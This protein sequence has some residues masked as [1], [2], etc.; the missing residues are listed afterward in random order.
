MGQRAADLASPA[1]PTRVRYQVL[2][3]A[4]SLAV[5]TYLQRQG[6]IA[7]TPYIKHDLKLDDE[8]LADLGVLALVAYGLFQVP[9]GMLGDRL[10]ARRLLTLLVFSWSILAGVVALARDLPTEGSLV[11]IFLGTQRFLFAAFQAGAFPGLTRVLADWMPARQRGFAQGMVWTFTR[12]GGFVAPI[13]VVWLITAIFGSREHPNWAIPCW[14]LAGVGLIWCVFFAI[15]FRNRPEEMSRVNAAEVA[16]IAAGRSAPQMAR[17]PLAWGMFFKLRNVWAICLM[18]GFLGYSGNFITQLLNVYLH[19][20]RHLGDNETAWAAGLPL[21]FG[22]V[23]CLLGGVVSDWLIRRLGDRKWGRR[24]VGVVVM[25]LAGLC[26][27][28][29]PWV[30]GFWPLALAFSAWFF[31]NDAAM[32]PAWASC[33]DV[34]DR[35]AGTL[36]GAMNMTGAFLGRWV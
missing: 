33:T 14:L 31:F 9:C 15:W 6:F 2:A 27:M 5:L 23:S 32:A 12:L 29:I 21:G 8:Q 24:L 20:H 26:S 35:H 34:G 18:Y 17:E 16:L 19:D 10:G 22:I 36:G 13:L 25:A 3:V 7:G 11:L 28:T 4:C 1:A 30:E